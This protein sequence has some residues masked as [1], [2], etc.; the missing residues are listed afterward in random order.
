MTDKIV[1][2]CTCASAEEAAKIA[3]HLVENRLAACVTIVP[4]VRS[5]YRWK[6]VV[7]DATEWLLMVKSRRGL[8]E[9]LSAEIASLHSYQVPEVVALPLVDGSPAY[10]NWL[11]REL[12]HE[13]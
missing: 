1:V 4:Q 7:E 9:K 3:R 12:S 5:I 2:L 10:L 11:D 13:E 8:V 6:G